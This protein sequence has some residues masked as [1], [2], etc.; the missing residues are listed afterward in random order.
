MEDT[1]AKTANLP[2]ED[3]Y[4]GLDGISSVVSNWE[5]TISTS[6]LSSVN[7]NGAFSPLINNSVAISLFESLDKSAKSIESSISNLA[8][9]LNS[10]VAE[11]N[12]IDK[13][14]KDIASSTPRYRTSGGSSSSNNVTPEDYDKT[15]DI[16][17]N[18]DVV[19][20]FDDFINELSEY[21]QVALISTL[22]SVSDNNLHELLFNENEA[23]KESLRIILE[24]LCESEKM[25]KELKETL[26][27]MDQNEIKILL[28]NLI[29]SGKT[30]SDFS[31]IIYSTT[32]FDKSTENVKELS[33][34]FIDAYGEISGDSIQEDLTKIYN[35]N[36]SIE[37]SDNTIQIT[38]N[39][40]DTIATVSN[41]PSSE[42][43]SNPSFTDELRACT[44]DL[45]KSFAYLSAAGSMG[46]ESLNTLCSNI[47]IG[48][49]SN[50]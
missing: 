35:G 46:D 21:E 44:A 27:K 14:G 3:M 36:A 49:T 5:K 37:V 20:Q 47:K 40:V 31:K 17:L 33:S 10:L 7:I 50:A 6:G 34:N 2:D 15:K 22:L 12:A 13:K 42:V 8:S 4:F 48:G 38:R 16:E 43:L 25:S 28:K 30:I 26:L 18:D 29:T 1:K 19:K 9:S 32:D 45:Y 24:K 39:F 41:V 11:Q 23:Y